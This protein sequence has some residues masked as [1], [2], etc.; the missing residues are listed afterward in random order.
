MTQEVWI[1]GRE[2]RKLDGDQEAHLIAVACGKAPEG[3]LR[4]RLHL[5][6]DKSVDAPNLFLASRPRGAVHSL[7]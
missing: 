4:W 5:L 3:Q 7:S 6:A 2:Y 1:A